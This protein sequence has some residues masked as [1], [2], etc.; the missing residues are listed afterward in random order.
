MNTVVDIACMQ[1]IQAEKRVD[2]AHYHIANPPEP[3]PQSP[4][5]EAPFHIVNRAVTL[6]QA[7]FDYYDNT[8]SFRV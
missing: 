2:H 4:L 7:M 8:L 1:I 5:E 3:H 6:N